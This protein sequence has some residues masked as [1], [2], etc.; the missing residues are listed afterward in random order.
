MT[1]IDPGAAPASVQSFLARV[2]PAIETELS[3]RLDAG[4]ER[5]HTRGR[6]AGIDRGHELG[7]SS[8]WTRLTRARPSIG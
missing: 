6:G 2:V 1:T 5:L 3:V 8:W 4:E 7:C